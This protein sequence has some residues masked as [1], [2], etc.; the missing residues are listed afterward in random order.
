MGGY[1]AAAVNAVVSIA[2]AGT[3]GGVVLMKAKDRIIGISKKM[4]K[5]KM[6]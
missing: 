5:K 3:T 1:G 6:S 4:F 2:G